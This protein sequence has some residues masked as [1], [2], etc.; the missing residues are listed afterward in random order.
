[1]S[2]ETS[3]SSILKHYISVAIPS[4]RIYFLYLLSAL[5]LAILSCLYFKYFCKN[6][7]NLKK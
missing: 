1:M 7:E 2:L 3:L 6:P 5:V 4:Q